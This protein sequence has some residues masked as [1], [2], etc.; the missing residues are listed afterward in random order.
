MNWMT[1]IGRWMARWR[2]GRASGKVRVFM[3]LD[4]PTERR[5]RR[6]IEA[7]LGRRPLRGTG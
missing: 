3:Q 5:I 4:R 6:G 1:A 7:R 2:G